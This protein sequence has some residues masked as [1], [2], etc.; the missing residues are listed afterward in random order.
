MKV[1]IDFIEDIRESI[2]NAEAYVLRVGLLK[3]D[4]EDTSKLHYLGE[5]S[6][7]SYQLSKEKKELLFKVGDSDIEVTVG[8]LIPS[9]LILDMQAMMYPLKI[10][11]NTQY[12][13][14]EVIGFGKSDEEKR[15]LLFIKV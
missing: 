14:L 2:E 5:A 4:L 10:D 12:S 1:I 7:E 15:Y 6:I 9:L 11:V 8:E 3:E 13:G